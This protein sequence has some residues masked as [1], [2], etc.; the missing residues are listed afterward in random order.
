MTHPIEQIIEDYEDLRE[1]FSAA[2]TLAGGNAKTVMM[3]P[4]W[5]SVMATLV[6]NNI[7]VTT[8]YEG[9]LKT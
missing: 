4:E 3:R 9:P 6:A 1:E 5:R 7:K 8:S 2:I